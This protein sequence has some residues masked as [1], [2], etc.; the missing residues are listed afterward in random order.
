MAEAPIKTDLILRGQIARRAVTL[1]GRLDGGTLAEVSGSVELKISLSAIL[2][3]LGEDYGEAADVLK[4]LV[5]SGD[6]VLEKLG[7]AYRSGPRPAQ[8][9]SLK[10][11]SVQVGLV[12]KI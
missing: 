8:N 6:I 12:I 2:K 9:E 7:A 11:G 3:D 4:Q 10:S 5:G 1:V